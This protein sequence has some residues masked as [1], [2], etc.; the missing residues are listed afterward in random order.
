[1]LSGD[2]Y[3]GALG[4][5]GVEK[6][7]KSWGERGSS[8]KFLKT[9]LTGCTKEKNTRMFGEILQVI[10]NRSDLKTGSN[11]PNAELEKIIHFKSE[12]HPNSMFSKTALTWAIEN[13]DEYMAMGLLKL[14]HDFHE[15]EE[16]GLECLQ[17]S[18]SNHSLLPWIFETYRNLYPK[19]HCM[20]SLK[21]VF[22]ELFLLTHL[23]F[24]VDI[25]SDISLAISYR[26][27]SSE[28]YT[29]T[30][31]WSCDT[32][33]INSSCYERIASDHWTS[34]DT[35]RD[36]LKSDDPSFF[37]D[38]H[39]NFSIGF[40]L[41]VVLLSFTIIFYLLYTAFVPSSDLLTSLVATRTEFSR[42]L[43]C[44]CTSKIKIPGRCCHQIFL[45]IAGKLLWPVVHSG[46]YLV[47]L[48]SPKSS[49]HQA[50]LDKI[51]AIW[52]NIKIVENGLESSI[53]LLLQVWLLRPFLPIILNWNLT[54]LI[55]R[56]TSG[57]ANFVSFG[58]YPACYIEQSL[59]KI[60][61]TIILL[62]L[63][64]SQMKKKPGQTLVKTLP[65]FASIFAQTL[66]RI[67]ALMSLV[68]MTTPLGYYKY[69]LFFVAHLLLVFLINI[70]LELKSKGRRR[71]IRQ[72]LT[73]LFNAI[74]STIVMLRL[75]RDNEGQHKRHPTFLSHASF[76]ILILLE[77][78]LLVFFPY[79]ANGRYYP[80]EDCLPANYQDIAICIVACA[81]LVGIIFQAIHYKCCSP[82]SKKNG[83]QVSSWYRPTKISCLA[84]L[85]WKREIQRIELCPLQYKDNR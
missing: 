81:W 42:T 55:R 22:I 63:A 61:L 54:E 75:H 28:N 84:T 20:S 47:Y 17:N 57:L 51:T 72:I 70:F 82:L 13:G 53:Q 79:I 38:I 14:E 40:W 31:L 48:S 68:L 77:N 33:H 50:N 15:N 32:I 5:Y 10:S 56:S 76:Q 52:N 80:T 58:I 43:C 60:L 39:I 45:I 25:S 35:Y 83:P 27:Y 3:F 78:L 34:Y 62:S 30:E 9:H 41:T 2:A 1:L 16:A 24:F 4:A 18:L 23:P 36:N 67:V 8:F 59:F 71:R 7:V 6:V 19:T 74:S 73:F 26:K 66:G 64:I 29:V 85:C 21:T 12:S 69:A 11:I 37:Q 44:R 46:G 65:M 49:Q